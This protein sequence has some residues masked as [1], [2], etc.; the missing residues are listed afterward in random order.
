MSLA[1]N[2]KQVL[3]PLCEFSLNLEVHRIEISVSLDTMKKDFLKR[4]LERGAE[5]VSAS[6]L[7]GALDLEVSP[8][9]INSEF[10]SVGNVAGQAISLFTAPLDTSRFQMK[11]GIPNLEQALEKE[12]RERA[13]VSRGF[14]NG[15]LDEGLS[16]KVRNFLDGIWRHER[17]HLVDRATWIPK[18][19][20]D[21]NSYNEEAKGRIFLIKN[22]AGLAIFSTPIIIGH[23]LVGP[24]DLIRLVSTGLTTG[25]SALLARN[26]AEIA[27]RYGF[28]RLSP[29][30]KRAREQEES[31]ENSL[32]IFDVRVSKRSEFW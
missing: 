20:D 11:V 31:G 13:S 15:Q 28:Y 29:E 21:R 8:K 32:G 3:D 24:Y 19:Y 16:L 14:S 7:S 27:A 4:A 10:G 23:F 30:E 12:V 26:V 22:I 2:E 1:E 6:Q 9:K 5:P 18:D 25:I 17:E